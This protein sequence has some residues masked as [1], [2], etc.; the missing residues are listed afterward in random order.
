MQY[1]QIIP[2]HIYRHGEQFTVDQLLHVLLI[3]SANDAANVLAEH[4]SGSIINFANLMNE[5]AKEI[6]LKNSNFTNPSGLHDEN[7]YTTAYDLSLLG[8]YAMRFDK[9]REIVKTTSYSLPAT[10]I[11]PQ[12]DRNFS[13]SNL[14]LDNTNSNYYYEYATGVKTGFTDPAG[15]CL[16]ASAKKDGI[17]FIA[18]CLNGGYLSNG[19]REKFLDCKTLLDYAFDNYTTHYIELQEKSF[20]DNQKIFNSIIESS[21]P[22]LTTISVDYSRLYIIFGIYLFLFFL[23]ILR[24]KSIR[25]KQKKKKSRKH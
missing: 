24:I 2:K 8:R 3:P 23:V 5:K 21:K 17:E 19:L 18:V 14:L 15:D 11:H 16:I 12:N 6:G 1:L 20:E 4:V 13:I 9:F 25:K 7:L 10:N 22:V